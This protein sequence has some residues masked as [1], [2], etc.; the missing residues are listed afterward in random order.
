MKFNI[1]LFVVL[2]FVA[3]EVVGQ[4]APYIRVSPRDARYFEYS[5]GKPYI[6]IGLNMIGM[7]RADTDQGMKQMEEWME[8]LAA[9]HGNYIRLW[10]SNEFWDV[11]H[12]KS[13]V[14]D[15]QKAE[16]RLDKIVA[17]AGELGIHVK[18]TL[19][20]FRNFKD[21]GWDAKA[22]HDVKNG[23]TATD[24]EDFFRGS[25]SRDLFRK[26]LDWYANRYAADPTI[27]LW[28]LWNEVNAVSHAGYALDASS[29]QFDWTVVMLKELKKRFPERLVT[30]S[31]GSFDDPRVELTYH[32]FMSISDN[33]VAQVHRY[34]DLGAA[35]EVCHG[36]VDVL[37]TDA[38]KVLRSFDLQKPILLAESGAVE[39]KHSGPF[40]LYA[41]DNEGILLHDI[42]FAPFFAGASGGGQ[43]WH[44][45]DYVAKN[46]LWFQFGRFAQAVKDIDPPA[47]GFEPL[48]ET[49]GILRVY[50]LKGKQTSLLWCRDTTN[51]WMTELRDG[52]TPVPVKNFSL[53]L[54]KFV[55]GSGPSEV[56]VYDPWTDKWSTV[57]AKNGKVVLPEFKRSIV[58][59][60][61]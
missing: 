19:E 56:R 46:N 58:V 23:G 45:N 12:E 15:E 17:K 6:P 32:A 47:E 10:L 59:R 22:L 9:N 3:G 57:K 60:I 27:F 16:E 51:N 49:Q 20:H 50:G 55:S 53:D 7:G 48:E 37:V 18:A 8:H 54:R 26:K 36:P 21:A 13:G 24:I 30:Q 61:I 28:E 14:Y 42:L 35:L 34:L 41:A 29:E 4:S 5:D 38:V 25:A 40:K 11:E 52:K 44:W 31:L 43:I 33:D 2:V 39:P 1:C